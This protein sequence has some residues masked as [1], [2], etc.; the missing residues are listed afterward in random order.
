MIPEETIEQVLNSTDIV[1]LIQSYFP[2]RRVGSDYTALC[3][4]HS[5]KTPSFTVSPAKQLYYC[6][7]CGAGG[8]VVRFLMQRESID[9]PTAIRRLGERAGIAIVE[10]D[11]SPE[12]SAKLKRRSRLLALHREAAAWF[13]W[14][15]LKKAIADGAREYLKNRG[16]G[17]DAA[18]DWQLGYAPREAAAL[19]DWARS[20]GY[21]EPLL[22]EAGL[23]AEREGSAGRLRVVPR[24]RDRLMFPVCNDFG[25]VIAFS[26]RTLDAEAK[27]AKYLNSPETPLFNKSKT[28]FGLHRSKRPILKAG[29][30]VICEG[31]IDLITCFSHGIEMMVAP[32]GTA[33]TPEHARMLKRLTQETVVCFDADA[34]GFKAAQRTFKALAEAN[35]FV[36]AVEMP[37]GEDP[38][39]YIR[40]F[41]AQAFAEL[42][43]QAPDFLEFQIAHRARTADLS[44]PREQH[45]LARELARDIALIR[46]KLMQDTLVN[47]VA[48]RLGI[49]HE[50]F[51]RTV[52]AATQRHRRQRQR[53]ARGAGEEPVEAAF[54]FQLNCSKLL[55]QMMLI[56]SQA[57]AWV[58]RQFQN[59]HNPRYL[60]DG[61]LIEQ[62]CAGRFD[63]AEPRSVS[64]YLGTLH[65]PVESVLVKLTMKPPKGNH[66][67][68]AQD[69]WRQLTSEVVRRRYYEVEGRLKKSDLE[70]SEMIK[71][72]GELKHLK[73]K[74]D[75]PEEGFDASQLSA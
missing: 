59:Y 73:E 55:C 31:Q 10:E 27:V 74:L 72:L 58:S 1:D 13:H 56:D 19:F 48:A 43:A 21:D 22:V 26:G 39:S 67:Q 11:R 61:S 49:A 51:R 71:L 69:A 41:G 57:K 28:L 44:S 23:A 60:P 52:F 40:K 42:L 20:K 46:D 36:R 30:A 29:H 68:A 2:L 16:L 33:F 14:N 64:H 47:A 35:L 18:R 37:Q 8:G 12:S 4:F 54:E 53:Q 50:E 25:E 63:A 34:A 5:E 70:T 7:G 15:L 32:L 65:G 6:F 45:E 66:L 62:I 17:I 75:R 3:P 9:F 24:F 38:D